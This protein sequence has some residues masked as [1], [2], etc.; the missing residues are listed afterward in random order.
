M[1]A[2]GLATIEPHTVHSPI[3]PHTG[4]QDPPRQYTDSDD[5][6]SDILESLSSLSKTIF[7]PSRVLH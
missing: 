7:P 2:G 5:L 4:G 3:N 1:T 6:P